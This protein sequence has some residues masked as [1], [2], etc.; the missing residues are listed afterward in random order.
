M[1]DIRDLLTRAREHFDTIQLEWDFASNGP[2]LAREMQRSIPN[3]EKRV[4]EGSIVTFEVRSK[5]SIRPGHA[6]EPWSRNRWRAW[7][8]KP[9]HWRDDYMWGEEAGEGGSDNGSGAVVHLAAG[10]SSSVYVPMTRTVYTNRRPDGVLARLKH[11]LGPRNHFELPTVE[12]RLRE[13]C[14]VD[15]SF[16]AS[17]WEL[18]ILGDRTHAGRAAV[19]AHAKRLSPGSEDG[20]ERLAYW[21]YIRDYEILVDRERG[22]LLRYA[23]IVDGEEAGVMSV[24]S[25]RFDDPI[26]DEIFAYEPPVG[27][28]IAWV[29][30]SSVER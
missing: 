7:W 17:D 9:S 27:T 18:S 26:P 30:G 2:V 3:Y 21:D 28:R 20:G 23:A 16:L 4:A 13:T 5:E 8:R 15:P 6:D 10:A 11:A 25:V 24:R 12:S 22:I 19:R 29:E 1:G 14:L